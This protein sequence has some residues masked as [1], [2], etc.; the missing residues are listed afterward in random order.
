MKETI[1]WFDYPDVKLTEDRVFD[2]FLLRTTEYVT[3]E[4]AML[5]IVGSDSCWWMIHGEDSIDES[6]IL[7]WAEMP[8]GVKNESNKD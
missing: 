2:W 1:E 5:L 7:K 8:R 6:T 4:Q 3:A